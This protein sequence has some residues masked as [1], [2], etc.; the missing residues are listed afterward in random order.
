MAITFGEIASKAYTTS[1][2]LLLSSWSLTAL[3]ITALNV[4]NDKKGFLAPAASIGLL[5]FLVCRLIAAV[6]PLPIPVAANRGTLAHLIASANYGSRSGAFVLFLMTWT[7][8]YQLL[9]TLFVL[10]LATTIGA[11]M[12]LLIVLGEPV[13]KEES[14]TDGGSATAFDFDANSTALVEFEEKLGVDPTD[15]IRRFGPYTFAVIIGL[16]WI[17][18]VSLCLYVLGHAARSFSTVLST[19]TQSLVVQQMNVAIVGDGAIPAPL[20]LPEPPQGVNVVTEEKMII[21]A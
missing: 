16:V 13:N 20:N 8:L 2:I 14:G 10:V 4:M 3:V 18:F 21:D 1:A 15:I 6:N 11:S 5:T 17:N 7:W 9:E 19:P 12:L